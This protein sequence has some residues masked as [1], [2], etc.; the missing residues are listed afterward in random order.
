MTQ[1]LLDI[2][3][4]PARKGQLLTMLVALFDG[5]A[6]DLVG[7]RDI[8]VMREVNRHLHGA[9]TIKA[10]FKLREDPPAAYCFNFDI[11]VTCAGHVDVDSNEHAASVAHTFRAIT[12]AE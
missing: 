12:N 6:D 11:G 1:E 9:L 7:L 10:N 4:G 3:S 8:K 2:K 5:I